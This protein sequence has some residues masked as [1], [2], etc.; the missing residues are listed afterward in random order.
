MSTLSHIYDAPTVETQSYGDVPI[1][2]T[3]GEPQAE[4]TALHRTSGLIDMPFRGVLE[5]T[6]RDRHTFLN[7][8][9]TNQLYDKNTKTPMASGATCYAFLLNAK[10]GRIIADMNVM[11]HGDRTLLETDA[12]LL[13]TLQTSLDRYLFSEQVKFSPQP[14]LHE[15]AIHGPT[16]A[17]V[18]RKVIDGGD[19]PGEHA[20]TTIRIIGQNVIA[21]HDDPCGVAGYSLIAPSSTIAAIWDHIVATCGNPGVSGAAVDVGR[22][23]LRPVGWAAFNTRRIE[24]GRPLFG[25]DFDEN[26]LAAETGQ[27]SRAVSF[28]KGCYP[29]QEIVARMHARQQVARQIVG[30]RMDGD[31][32]PFAGTHIFD[33][34]DNQIG[35]ITSSTVS[36]IRSNAMIAIG[37]LKKPFFAVGTAVRVPA[38]G[39]MREAKVVALP[40]D[41]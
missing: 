40:F 4:Y 29:G 37:V 36:P 20:C 17:D 23:L 27:L 21:W 41:R 9:L 19:V 30:I 22:R 31:A 1:I 11:E 35:G 34:N 13:S 38:E 3:F 5:V 15:I 8:L 24:A 7:N 18:L 14:D 33:A 39:A 26:F 32:L 16:A 28:T 6:G 25:I 2:T 10:N 12:R